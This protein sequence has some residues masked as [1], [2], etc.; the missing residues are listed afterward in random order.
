MLEILAAALTIF[1]ASYILE[2]N[3]QPKETVYLHRPQQST[4][5]MQSVKVTPNSAIKWRNVVRQ[6]YDFSCGSAAI[7]TLLKYYV[8]ETEINELD[9]MRG[10]LRRGERQKIIQRQGF[11]LL[12]MKRYVEFLGY[13]ANG[14][15][16][17][18]EDIKGLERPVII[19]YQYGGFKH[20]VVLRD[21]VNGHA[22]IADPAFGN[23][24]LTI[25]KFKQIWQPQVLFRVLRGDKPAIN[26]LRL[27]DSDLRYL[28]IQAGY[29]DADPFQRFHL[30]DQLNQAATRAIRR[31]LYF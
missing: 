11:S 22:L 3:P 6:R 19:P 21:I 13:Q 27:Q 9:A 4:R 16:G 15:R 25:T 23:L 26:D 20:F 18:L 5:A 7:S 28:S 17:D 8:G 14:F 2:P 10:M 24:S 29:G 12:D 1:Q 31:S 30:E